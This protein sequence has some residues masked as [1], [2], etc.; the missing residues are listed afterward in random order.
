MTEILFFAI[1]V[2]P[3]IQYRVELGAFSFAVMEPVV[4]GAS[5]ALILLPMLSRRPVMV[6]KDPLLLLL[7]GLM[8]WVT[9]TRP[10]QADW[11]H[12]L[13]D[14]R[15]WGIPVLAYTALVSSPSPGWRKRAQLL[16]LLAVA[17]SGM[18]IFQHF[19][20]SSRPFVDELASFKTSFALTETGELARAS[21][22]VALFAHPNG[23]AI[24][25][26]LALMTAL[27][28]AGQTRWKVAATSAAITIALALYWTYA[29]ASLVAI[30]LV[31]GA[32]VLS[33]L[34]RS[35]PRSLVITIVVG[36]LLGAWVAAIAAWIPDA[37]LATFRWRLELWHTALDIFARDPEVLLFGN[38]MS[39]FGSQAAYP[40]PHSLYLYSGLE[41]G[42][43]GVSA[44]ILLSVTVLR[45]GMVASRNGVLGGSPALEGLWMGL[46][47][48][49]VI[50]FV[51]SNLL[52]IELRMI[53][54]I[55]AS[56]F[57]V[58]VSEELSRVNGI[59]RESFQ[60]PLQWR[61]A[62]GSTPRPRTV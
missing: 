58:G 59:G 62:S 39:A 26:S 43:I 34:L 8:L 38:G 21:Y 16:V 47:G 42:L 52:G 10:W 11:E 55:A 37:W 30:V 31:V 46:L 28:L 50:G 45:Q 1:L 9:L 5:L 54:L 57:Q 27:G 25:L 48:F 19:T 49:F 44:I 3:T 60:G 13:S 41:Y 56:T 61:L 40:Q 17:Y 29:K 12:G 36:C 32:F 18:G 14:L 23:F 2:G 7:L 51:E 35:I 20:N 53:F 24:F 6:R 22:A 15:D 33:R 4:I